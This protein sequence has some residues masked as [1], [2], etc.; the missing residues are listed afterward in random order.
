MSS[1]CR[2]YFFAVFLIATPAGAQPTEEQCTCLADEDVRDEH[3]TDV[4]NAKLCVQS[5]NGLEKWCDISVH[6]LD[7]PD[8]EREITKRLLELARDP[9]EMSE[10]IV[11]DKL[12]SVNGILLTL[13]ESH[14]KHSR[15]SNF[16]AIDIPL[17]AGSNEAYASK[18]LQ[19]LFRFSK[20]KPVSAQDEGFRCSVSAINGWLSLSYFGLRSPLVYSFKVAPLP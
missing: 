6:E 19:C 8:E 10:K 16:V 14:K 5:K 17:I 20:G 9:S 7:E 1:A 3:G 2:Y 13:L 15:F 4:T 11:R 18:V 12:V